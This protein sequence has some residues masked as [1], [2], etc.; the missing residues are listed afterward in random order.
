MECLIRDKIKLFVNPIS[1]VDR[2][3]VKQYNTYQ[4]IAMI[5]FNLQL[6]TTK[7]RV[8]MTFDYKRLMKNI[9]NL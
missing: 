9:G 4:C 7:T 2:N 1:S 5:P 6:F 3:T 8:I